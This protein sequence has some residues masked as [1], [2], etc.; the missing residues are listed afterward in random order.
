M[1]LRRPVVKLGAQFELI[2]EN[3]IGERCY[4]SPAISRGQIF[5]RSEKHLFCIGKNPK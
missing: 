1:K 3:A 4:A 5:I 2:A